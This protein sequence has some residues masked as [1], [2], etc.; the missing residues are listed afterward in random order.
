MKS[1]LKSSFMQNECNDI[2]EQKDTKKSKDKKLSNQE[3]EKRFL[4]SSNKIKYNI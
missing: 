3:L 4:V 1:E 2:T